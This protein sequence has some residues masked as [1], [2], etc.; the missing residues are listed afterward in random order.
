MVEAA[1]ENMDIKLSIFKDMD[2]H[3]LN[4]AYYQP[5]HH[6]YPLQIAAATNRA[7]RVIGMH[8]MNPVPIMKLVEVIKGYSTSDKTLD[9]IM[10][11]LKIAIKFPWR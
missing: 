10:E 9:T 3:A 2:Q 11:R 1:T 5:T 4:T 8:F 7:D 6:L